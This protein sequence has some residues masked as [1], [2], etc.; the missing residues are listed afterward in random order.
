MCD[1]STAAAGRCDARR[2][3]P[4]IDAAPA[5]PHAGSPVVLSAASPGRGVTYAWDLDGDGAYD[6]GT[7][8]RI[9]TTSATAAVRA[10]DAD[11]RS[12]SE[13]R[14]LPA[15]ASNLRPSGRFEV[16]TPSPGPARVTD[17][18]VDGDRRGRAGRAHR[19]RPRRRRRLRAAV[20]VRPRRRGA[21]R[22]RA[23]RPDRRHP[24]AARAHRRR[25]G[26]DDDADDHAA[27]ASRQPSTAGRGRGLSGGAAAG[28]A[29]GRFREGD[30][31]RRR[32][33]WAWRSIST[34]TARTRPTP[35]SPRA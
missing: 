2:P 26:G 9:I 11:G 23:A 8:A 22:A 18:V 25:R 24:H 6:D 14:T 32:R 28:G 7:G 27:G 1:S 19:P 21:R 16:L 20:L 34:A 35:A 13:A 4:S 33:T 10:T 31:S 17:V 3:S 12:G 30:R 5:A 29:G 15:H